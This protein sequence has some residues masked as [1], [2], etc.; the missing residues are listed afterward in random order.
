MQ[1]VLNQLTCDLM[2]FCKIEFVLSMAQQIDI[3]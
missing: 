3:G 1:N 2:I